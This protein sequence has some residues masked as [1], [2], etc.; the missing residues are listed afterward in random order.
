MVTGRV[1]PFPGSSAADADA[2]EMGEM[3]RALRAA[4]DTLEGQCRD[5]EALVIENHPECGMAARMLQSAGRKL[6]G[7]DELLK[8]AITHL[9][10]RE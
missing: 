10:A 1:G 5:L 6:L 8:A 2:S 7:V 9:Q 4:V 3:V